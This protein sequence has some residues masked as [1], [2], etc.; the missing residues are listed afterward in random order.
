MLMPDAKKAAGATPVL[1]ITIFS[2]L[3]TCLM[4]FQCFNFSAKKQMK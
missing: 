4:Y 2:F 3:L 1:A